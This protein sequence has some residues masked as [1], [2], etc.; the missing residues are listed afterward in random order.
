MIK[1]TAYCSIRHQGVANTAQ[2]ILLRSLPFSVASKS[3]LSD[4][5]VYSPYKTQNI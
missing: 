2:A 3:E 4:N 5:R 1:Q